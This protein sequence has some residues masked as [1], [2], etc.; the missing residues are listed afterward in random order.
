[1]IGYF[2][3]EVSALEAEHDRLI[4]GP[5]FGPVMIRIGRGHDAPCALLAADSRRAPAAGSGTIA[6]VHP[7]ELVG[8]LPNMCMYVNDHVCP[9]RFGRRLGRVAHRRASKCC[10]F[11][12][13]PVTVPERSFFLEYALKRPPF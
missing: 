8:R 2:G 13:A 11:L 7:T 1:M 3:L 12:I 6:Q 5:A 9:S 10:P 4:D